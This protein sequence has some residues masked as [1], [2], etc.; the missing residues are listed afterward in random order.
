MTIETLSLAGFTLSL[1]GFTAAFEE[2]SPRLNKT[3][4]WCLAL[5]GSVLW[6]GLI[7]HIAT[8]AMV[9]SCLGF[10]L[11]LVAVA[12][13]CFAERE[14]A[15]R[16]TAEEEPAWWPKFERDFQ[17]YARHASDQRGTG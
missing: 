11:S 7:G 6:I 16:E 5:T 15:E 9:L 2:R 12:L 1:A 8:W 14:T 13:A 10:L 4:W 17:N 3:R